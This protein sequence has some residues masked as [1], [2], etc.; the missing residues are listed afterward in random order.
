VS[1]SCS[2]IGFGGN[3]GRP[4]RKLPWIVQEMSRRL[5]T[6]RRV[7]RVFRT[8]PWGGASGPDYINAVIELQTTRPACDILQV[9][10]GLETACG[11]E[12]PY[13]NAPRTCDLD[14]L[15]HG[16][17][18]ISEPGLDVPHPRLHLRRFVLAPLCDL[19][20]REKHPVI[21][22]SFR[23]LLERVDDDGNA[24]PVA[25]AKSFSLVASP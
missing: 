12:R 11:R 21:G 15:L 13:S 25:P 24:F 4:Q 6:V 18:I 16:D 23:E 20:P 17:E 3:L 19:V 8:T 10:Q 22:I 5:G 2:Y 1:L 7:S 9:L 14:L